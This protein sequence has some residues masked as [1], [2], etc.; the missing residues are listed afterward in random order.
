MKIERVDVYHLDLT[1]VHGTYVMSGGR[2]ISSLASTLVRVTADGVSGWGE[3]CPLGSTYLPGH[4][5]GARAAR[6]ASF[7]RQP[8]LASATIKSSAPVASTTRR[9]RSP[10][11]TGSPPILS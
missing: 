3:V 10:S 4:A 11:S 1:Y 7:S 8:Q 5:E 2:E 6:M 9:A